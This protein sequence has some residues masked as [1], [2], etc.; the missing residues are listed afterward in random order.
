MIQVPSN[1][2]LVWFTGCS[3]KEQKEARENLV[4]N[5]TQVFDI[6]L[7]I[8]RDKAEIIERKGLREEDY[9]EAGWTTLS[10]FRNGKLA[11]LYEIADLLKFNKG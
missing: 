11:D 7:Q 4:R 10:A 6:L 3:T 2:P 8:L 1:L 9:A 5:S